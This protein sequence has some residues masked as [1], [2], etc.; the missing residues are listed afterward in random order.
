MRMF[1]M[2]GAFESMLSMSSA[3]LNSGEHPDF[4]NKLKS[5]MFTADADLDQIKEDEQNQ[6]E[7]I[8]QMNFVPSMTEEELLTAK[9]KK[10]QES[11]E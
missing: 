2:N 10:E 9:L 1:S 6:E 11:E 5:R 8:E 7:K 4:Q 3:A